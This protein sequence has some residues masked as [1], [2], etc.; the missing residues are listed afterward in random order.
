MP[1]AAR[2]VRVA[3]VPRDIDEAAA[4]AIVEAAE[5][6]AALHDELKVALEVGDAARVTELARRIVGLEEQ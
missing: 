5:Q 4:T 1:K 2:A 6:W 3:A